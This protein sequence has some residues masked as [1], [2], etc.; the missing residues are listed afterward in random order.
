MFDNYPNQEEMEVP[1]L[2]SIISRGGQIWFSIK[3]NEL[4]EELANHYSLSQEMRDYSSLEI[5]A[6][7][8]RKWRN[9]IQYVRLRLVKKGQID[10][11]TR[12]LWRVTEAG[13][14]RLGLHPPSRL[15]SIAVRLSQF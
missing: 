4:E 7:G 2:E 5:N 15:E 1:L 3:G 12:D 14:D 9:H 6:K 10:N 11:S 8:H 13:Y